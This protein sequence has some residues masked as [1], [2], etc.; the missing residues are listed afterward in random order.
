MTDSEDEIGLVDS[1]SEDS[2][3]E[4]NEESDEEEDEDEDEQKPCFTLHSCLFPKSAAS[5]PYAPK[6]KEQFESANKTNDTKEEVES[7]TTKN[8]KCCVF[9]HTPDT[10]QRRQ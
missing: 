10:S 8:R 2:E 5:V 1:E 3:S 9:P 6:C 4:K 7:K